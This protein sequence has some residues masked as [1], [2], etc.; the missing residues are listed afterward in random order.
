MLIHAPRYLEYRISEQHLELLGWRHR[1]ISHRFVKHLSNYKQPPRA[2]SRRCPTS[3]QTHCQC[4]KGIHTRRYTR[5]HSHDLLILQR[6]TNIEDKLAAFNQSFHQQSHK[7]VDI[8]TTPLATH[9]KYVPN[10]RW[11]ELIHTYNATIS[12]IRGLIGGY[13]CIAR[14]AYLH[15]GPATGQLASYTKSTVHAG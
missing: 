1:G 8:S 9:R 3:E 15:S 2:R 7:P 10:S 14:P 13:T 6:R 12:F 11:R 5:F 4:Q